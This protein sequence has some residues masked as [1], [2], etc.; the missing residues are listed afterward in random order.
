MWSPSQAAKPSGNQICWTAGQKSLHFPQSGSSRRN[1][2]FFLCYPIHSVCSG[3]QGS[4]ELQGSKERRKERGCVCQRC[5]MHVQRMRDKNHGFPQPSLLT[6]G[7]F[8]PALSASSFRRR[9]SHFHSLSQ[10]KGRFACFPL[11][12]PRRNAALPQAFAVFP[13]QTER[14]MQ[15]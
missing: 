5:V 11:S 15:H 1:Q 10:L 8:Q 13:P 2:E 14:P 3:E 9:H 6:G 4:C 7:A 12:I